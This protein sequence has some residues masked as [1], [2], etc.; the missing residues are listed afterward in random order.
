M[1]SEIS[2][3]AWATPGGLALG[4][5]AAGRE[6]ALL[7]NGMGIVIPPRVDELGKDVFTAGVGF[8]GHLFGL[9]WGRYLCL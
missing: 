1:E 6:V 9:R 2:A 8:V 7:G 5:N 4:D 3:F